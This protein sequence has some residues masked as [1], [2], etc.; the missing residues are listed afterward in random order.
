MLKISLLAQTQVAATAPRSR[1]FSQKSWDQ[2][3]SQSPSAGEG[4]TNH[5]ASDPV[6]TGMFRVLVAAGLTCVFDPVIL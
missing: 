1:A 2:K 3:P 6:R 5:A 4:L